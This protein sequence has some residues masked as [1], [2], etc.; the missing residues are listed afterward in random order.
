MTK[1]IRMT[2]VAMFRM[3]AVA[4]LGMT[5]KSPFYSIPAFGELKKGRNTGLQVVF[6]RGILEKSLILTL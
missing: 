4:M 5:D 3:T 2:A 1:K 6:E